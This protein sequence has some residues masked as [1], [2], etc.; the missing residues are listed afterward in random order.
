[1]LSSVVDIALQNGK[2]AELARFKHV[3][4]TYQNQVRE[5]SSILIF[6]NFFP[7][8]IFLGGFFTMA[9]FTTTQQTNYRVRHFTMLVTYMIQLHGPLQ[10]LAASMQKFLD[11]VV[12]SERM[13]SVLRDK[14]DTIEPKDAREMAV[15]PAEIAFESISTTS[16]E[17]L[18]FLCQA[19]TTITCSGLSRH[20]REQLVSILARI[21]EPQ[22]GTIRINALD[23][24]AY[25]IKSLRRNF[26]FVPQE[27]K[28]LGDTVIQCLTYGLDNPESIDRGTV[29]AA[30]K[31]VNIHDRI[32]DLS[33]GYDTPAVRDSRT[34]SR[35][36]R[37]RFALVTTIV[38]KR[39]VLVFDGA[40]AA[41]ESETPAKLQD[42]I[43]AAC[44]GRTVIVFE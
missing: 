14:T 37:R 10:S 28:L 31:A 11:E 24:R 5:S 8:T 43:K 4:A 17:P 34:F 15:A 32:L 20:G 26:G 7:N 21:D 44:D 6:Q 23:I 2:E 12:N 27:Y 1:M 30:C 29:I 18:T 39:G 25:S 16:L 9:V 3:H 40:I 42:T 13:V 33:G 38:G 35:E 22:L 19:G 41:L 36:E